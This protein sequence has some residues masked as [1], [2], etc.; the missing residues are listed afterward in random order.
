MSWQVFFCSAYDW[1]PQAATKQLNISGT[2][3]LR[4]LG[5]FVIGLG[6]APIGLLLATFR[7]NTSQN[8][9]DNEQKQRTAED[10]SRSVKLLGD[11]SAAVRQGGIYAL[12]FLAR[13]S[14]DRYET[15]IKIVASYIRGTKDTGKKAKEHADTENQR[16]ITVQI[17][18]EGKHENILAKI[19]GAKTQT[20]IAPDGVDVEAALS[21]IKNR[22]TEWD[23]LPRREGEYLFDL[24]NSVLR[25][26][27]LS[28]AKLRKVNL[29]EMRA[30]GCVFA[31]TDF[32]EANMVACEFQGCDFRKTI[33][34]GAQLRDTKFLDYCVSAEKPEKCDLK[35]A[36][37]SGA[38]LQ[39]A[40]LTGARGLTLEQIKT[41]K[42]DKS[43]KFPQG[44]LESDNGGANFDRSE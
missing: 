39:G 41:A 38:E 5:L 6:V 35:D 14:K 44:L 28:N 33:F 19:L 27:D 34:K 31:G 40:D 25:Y 43:T 8:Q 10:F 15:A 18:E 32:T 26:G 22:K 16:S 7:T 12:G 1:L 2:D 11:S 13:E 20:N 4:G 17:A 3:A 37:L 36:D 24:S 29:S 23:K 42:Y 21:V 30:D 9:L